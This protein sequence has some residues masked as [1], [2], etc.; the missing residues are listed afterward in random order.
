M[1]LI[2]NNIMTE[3]EYFLKENNYEDDL[4]FQLCDL[5]IAFN[6]G[7]ELQWKPSDEQMEAL[8]EAYKG[9][10]EQAALAS[11][12]SDLKKLKD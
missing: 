6:A 3:F 1:I 4:E 11:L 2:E 9:G 7:K 5:E 12:Y 8:W 10:E